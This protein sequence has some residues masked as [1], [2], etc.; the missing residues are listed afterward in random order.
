MLRLG[1]RNHRHSY[2]PPTS[3]VPLAFPT[4]I[5][6]QQQPALKKRRFANKGFQEDDFTCE[7]L[8]HM[9]WDYAGN[10]APASDL[11]GLTTRC[12][13]IIC[14]TCTTRVIKVNHELRNVIDWEWIEDYLFDDYECFYCAEGY[15]ARAATYHEAKAQWENDSRSVVEKMLRKCLYREY[16]SAD[17]LKSKETIAAMVE[18]TVNPAKEYGQKHSP[19]FA[20]PPVEP[21]VPEPMWRSKVG[22]NGSKRSL[23]SQARKYKRAAVET[24]EEE[25]FENHNNPDAEV[26]LDEI[27]DVTTTAASQHSRDGRK[28]RP[29]LNASQQDRSVRSDAGGKRSRAEFEGDMKGVKA[30]PRKR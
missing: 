4:E 25:P 9:L 12:V 24:V 14:T 6:Q 7:D 16:A 8:R 29:Q 1:Y 23:S 28:E 3:V 5:V 30:G 21:E 22:G 11:A 15:S 19:T 18:N 17:P 27:S 2:R 13:N 26:L 10:P 20:E